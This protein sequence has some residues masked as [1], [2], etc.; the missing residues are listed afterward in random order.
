MI[1]EDDLFQTIAQRT[2]LSAREIS[3]KR[4]DPNQSLVRL[5]A[6][7]QTQ[8]TSEQT[9]NTSSRQFLCP[10]SHPFFPR[11]R[12]DSHAAIHQIPEYSTLFT[13]SATFSKPFESWKETK[14]ASAARDRPGIAPA[15]SR[16]PQDY[17]FWKLIKVYRVVE[18]IP[19]GDPRDTL[20]PESE[21]L[22]SPGQPWIPSLIPAYRAYLPRGLT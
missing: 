10:S 2:C 18:H 11:R 1:D 8:P 21:N 15:S 19:V 5:D 22:T 16:I 6:I 4:E 17:P 20:S 7:L 13:C 12:P 3:L 9:H 14:I